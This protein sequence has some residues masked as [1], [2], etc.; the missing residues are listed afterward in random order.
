MSS[1]DEK[2]N[3]FLS[4]EG[5]DPATAYKIAG[6]ASFRSYYRCLDSEGAS[7]VVMDAPPEDGEDCRPFVAIGRW[8]VAEG[9]SAPAIVAE[10]VDQGFLL[11]ED[12][13]DALFKPLLADGTPF[14]TL[15]GPAVDLLV[16]LAQI[17]A[18]T[19]LEN[20]YVLP[21]YDETALETEVL[22]LTDW[23]YP[24]AAGRALS[25]QAREDYLAC[26]RALWPHV[27][28]PE[29]PVLV[30]RDY[31]A[32]NLLWL[33][34]R[35]GT[36][37]VGLLDF[38]DGLAGHAAYDLIS[39]TDDARRDVSKPERAFMFERYA[40]ARQA[41]DAD[42][43]YAAFEMQ[44]EILAAQRNAKIVGIFCRLAKRDGKPQYLGLLPRVW[45]YLLSNVQHPAMADLAAWFD[46]HCP[47]ALRDAPVTLEGRA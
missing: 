46:T 4:A 44:A 33:P 1:R 6:D 23:Y 10:D 34:E 3:A 19:Q 15:Y 12:L 2:R 13:G 25:Q 40:A 7:L 35:D 11:L 5:I 16:E 26:W 32:E 39:L 22:L 29:K 42:F 38:Q 24:L 43:D 41:I 27:A 45:R 14:E 28:R 17:P 20:G 31:H 21:P 37:K 18:P 30:L 9:F 8:L 47:P 36:A